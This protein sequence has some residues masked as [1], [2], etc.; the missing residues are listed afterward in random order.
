MKGEGLFN[1][2]LMVRLEIYQKWRDLE[3]GVGRE[4]RY[5]N[6]TVN[7]ISEEIHVD[8]DSSIG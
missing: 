2:W 4:R 6:R 1:L 3:F 7:K 5:V 8:I